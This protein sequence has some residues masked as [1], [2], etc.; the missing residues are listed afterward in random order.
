[1]GSL[2]YV[3]ACRMNLAVLAIV[4]AAGCAASAQEDRLES[5]C[6]GLLHRYVFDCGCTT[7]FLNDHFGAEQ[8]DILLKLWVYGV[9]GDNRSDLHN[10]YLEHGAN[11]INETVMEFQRHRDR[12]R[13]YCVQGEG[14]RIAD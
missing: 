2:S 1:M 14:P 11:K 13:I 3:A 12:L 9:N 7:R 10:L 4:M 6:R 8:A 5:A